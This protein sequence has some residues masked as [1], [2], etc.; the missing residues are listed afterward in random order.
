MMMVEL[1][2]ADEAF[3]T[4]LERMLDNKNV[5]RVLLYFVVLGFNS[6]LHCV[7]IVKSDPRTDGY[8]DHLQVS[9]IHRSNV[10]ERAPK[11]EA[12]VGYTST[13]EKG[14]VSEAKTSG[15]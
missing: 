2:S 14:P 7:I 8:I 12:A 5:V 15:P 6:A 13:H 9:Y 4:R 11:R 1:V 3:G 10:Y